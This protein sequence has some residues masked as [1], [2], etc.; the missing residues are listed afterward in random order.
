MTV[1]ILFD[2]DFG[3]DRDDV[4][5][6]AVLNAFRDNSE[7]ELLAMITQNTSRWAA[8]GLDAINTYY[9]HGDIPIGARQPV[10][11][12]PGRNVSGYAEH[13]AKNYPNSVND[14]ALCPEAVGLYRQTLSGQPDHS[15][16]AVVVGGMTNLAGLLRSRP[17][18]H[19]ELAG[20]DLVSRK[21]VKLV[22]MGT[23]LPR[24]REFNIRL[25]PEAARIVAAE[26][27]T[28]VV[29]SDWNVG[30]TVYSGLRLFS[31][32]PADNPVRVAWD[33]Y[34]PVQ[35]Q[36]RTHDQI[37]SYYAVRGGGGLFTLSDPGTVTIAP[38]GWSQWTDDPSGRH[39]YLIKIAPDD[40]IA[41]TVSDLMVQQPDAE[42]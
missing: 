2:T 38:D 1:K 9:G 27:P 24:G 34:N 35:R 10:E 42:G 17:D 22:A 40:T 39:R 37:A 8:P 12:D 13:L 41:D 21:I 26:W 29:Y 5:A 15:V 19:S 28:L 3:G 31:E 18:E 36:G 4:G 23:R 7:A 11:D 14:G 20:P 33:L 6:V 16:V 25:D 30:G 32:T